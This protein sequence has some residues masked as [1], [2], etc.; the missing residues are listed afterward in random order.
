MAESILSLD[1][2]YKSF[3]GVCAASDVTF[4][5]FPGQIMGLIGPNG[6]GKSTILNLISGIYQVDQGKI[7]F[8][9]QDVTPLPAH[10]RAR[11]GIGRT[12]QTPRFLYRSA[13][14]EN[15]LLGTD[16][17]DQM[18][19]WK[20][21]LG[22]KGND[23]DSEY[24]RLM[25]IVGFQLSW[26]EHIDSLP[27]GRRKL[28]EIVR[29]LLSHP[30][31]LLIDEPAA[32]LNTQESGIVTDLVEYA[33]GEKNIGVLLIEHQMDM[34]MNTCDDLVVLN[35]GKL[36]ASGK[37]AEISTNQSV[38]EAYLGREFHVEDN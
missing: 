24:S 27:Y 11:L 7:Y 23:F 19:Y 13:I 1:H 32:G 16:L 12:F 29:A 20:S 9:G 35:F 34:V 30:K 22:K 38:I 31:V 17:A 28:L 26:D 2:V 6:A 18:G 25:E 10:K 36:I 5:V 37:P 14:R 4:A 8:N 21:F 15:M 3:G 33:T